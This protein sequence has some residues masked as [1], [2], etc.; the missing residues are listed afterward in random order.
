MEPAALARLL[1]LDPAPAVVSVTEH[2]R[3]TLADHE[4][5]ALTLH[6]PDGDRI[7]ALFLRPF[8]TGP[9]P[10]VVAHHQHASEW[11]FGKSEVAGIVGDPHQAFGGLGGGHRDEALSG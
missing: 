1:T 3:V 10:A 5:V 11:H 6:A 9:F 7:P 2:A 8:G 4:R